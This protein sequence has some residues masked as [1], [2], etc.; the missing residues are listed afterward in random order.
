MKQAMLTAM[1]AVLMVAG[2]SGAYS[3]V[4]MP[5]P[6]KRVTQLQPP[7]TQPAAAKPAATP[8][9][10][11]PAPAGV[12]KIS[13]APQPELLRPPVPY[14]HA[15]R[16]PVPVKEDKSADKNDKGA[17]KP[18]DKPADTAAAPVPAAE[19]QEGARL[20]RSAIERDGYRAVKVVS[21]SAD[22]SWRGRAMR[23]G[24][25]VGVTVDAGGNVRVD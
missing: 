2:L 10:T 13:T 20:A 6:P 9:A 7:L 4:S 23:G 16:P 11:P 1:G 22:G 19:D 17:D 8:Q 14:L 25:E 24:T 5:E 3:F 21:K 12:T 18:A 15:A